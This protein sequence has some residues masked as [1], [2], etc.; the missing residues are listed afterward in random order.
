MKLLLLGPLPPHR[1]TML[2]LMAWVLA[3]PSSP[4]PVQA[5]I[6]PYI[7]DCWYTSTEQGS[8]MNPTVLREAAVVQEFDT[9]PDEYEFNN[10][11]RIGSPSGMQFRVDVDMSSIRIELTSPPTPVVENNDTTTAIYYTEEIYI[12]FEDP[13]VSSTLISPMTTGVD[14]ETLP[15]N[16]TITPQDATNP[17]TLNILLRTGAIRVTY[18]TF[19]AANFPTVLELD[20]ALDLSDSEAPTVAPSNPIM[21]STSPT[22]PTDISTNGPTNDSSGTTHAWF[23]NSYW[24]SGVVTVVVVPLIVSLVAT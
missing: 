6:V 16:T 18:D 17:I 8:S 12:A 4:L 15:L 2:A 14:V 11:P 23:D 7:I 21:T 1:S 13:L 3:W 5:N 9:A 24:T 22:V 20:Y 10:L 19:Y